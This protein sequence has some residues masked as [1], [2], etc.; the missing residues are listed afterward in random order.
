MKIRLNSISLT[1][2]M[3]MRKL[4]RKNILALTVIYSF[5]HHKYDEHNLLAGKEWIIPD[6]KRI[7]M[8]NLEFTPSGL[9]AGKIEYSERG[10]LAG[11]R[12]FEYQ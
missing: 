11:M 8:T 10:K 6:G 2:V 12:K 5:I 9:I 7:R 3:S 1:I 4:N